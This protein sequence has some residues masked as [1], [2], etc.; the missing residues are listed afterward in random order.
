M[1]IDLALYL[2][3]GGGVLAL[4]YALVKSR[5]I[6]NQE[7]TVPA[8]QEIGGH[9]AEGAMAFLT[10]EYKVLTPFLL[11]VASTFASDPEEA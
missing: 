3:L 4:A 6:K 10:R 5:W 1:I 8:L 7:L 11:V 9:I 2:M